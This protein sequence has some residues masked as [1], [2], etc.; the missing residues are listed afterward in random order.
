MKDQSTSKM[1]KGFVFCKGFFWCLFI[2]GTLANFY[3]AGFNLELLKTK[4]SLA[5]VYT[6]TDCTIQGPPLDFVTAVSLSMENG[7]EAVPSKKR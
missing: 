6:N 4:R 1:R 2:V 3:L 7:H 5:V